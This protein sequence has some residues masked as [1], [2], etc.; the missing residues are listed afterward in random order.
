MILRQG[1]GFSNT[2]SPVLALPMGVMVLHIVVLPP[3]LMGL[4]DLRP[5]ACVGERMVSEPALDVCYV[6]F[7]KFLT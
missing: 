6:E 3:G 1:Y 7:G 5:G 4:V 2:V